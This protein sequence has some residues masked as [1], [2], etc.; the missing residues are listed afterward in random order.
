MNRVPSL[1]SKL[2][3]IVGLGLLIVTLV[4]TDLRSL[5]DFALRLGM[6]LPLALLPGA[7]WHALRTEAWR[8]SFP[9][10]WRPSFARSF[11]IRLAAEAFSYLTISGVAGEPVKIVLLQDRVTPPVSAAAVAL[12]RIAYILVTSVLVGAFGLTAVALLPL[13]PGWQLVFSLVA[14]FAL[15]ALALVFAFASINQPA[16]R[17]VNFTSRR[18][19][20]FSRFAGELHVQ[21]KHLVS[22]DRRRL[23]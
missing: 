9:G 2:A 3:L 11:R 23:A 6:V 21:F 10:E 14:F 19:S 8:R 18:P 17:E 12:E 1:F 15:L 22:S 4:T 7:M 5:G 13:T 20:A 16:R